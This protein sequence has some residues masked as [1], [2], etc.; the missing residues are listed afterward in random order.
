MIF[1]YFVTELWPLI[2]VRFLFPLNI[3]RTH[4]LNFTKFCVLIDINKI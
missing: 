1:L 4:K 3:V 2:D